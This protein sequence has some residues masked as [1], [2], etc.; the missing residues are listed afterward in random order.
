MGFLNVNL[1]EIVSEIDAPTK[2][3]SDLVTGYKYQQYVTKIIYSNHIIYIVH[4]YQ[5]SIPS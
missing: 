2:G 1:D 5:K 3:V 4:T